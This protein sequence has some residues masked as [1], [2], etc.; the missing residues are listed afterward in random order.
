LTCLR[1]EICRTALVD[2]L[3]M[4]HLHL[5]D[6][7]AETLIKDEMLERYDVERILKESE[8]NA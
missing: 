1:V 5:L 3:K 4:V 6:A 7:L 8:A 2:A